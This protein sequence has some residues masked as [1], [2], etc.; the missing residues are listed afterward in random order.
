M[1]DPLATTAQT[2]VPPTVG[3]SLLDPN[4]SGDILRRYQIARNEEAA[5]T[6]RLQQAALADRVQ[7]DRET[8]DRDTKDYEEAQAFKQ[9]RG[10]VLESI[11]G[12][13]PDSDDYDTMVSD[14]LASAPEVAVKDDAVQALLSV[15]QRRR[16]EN[17]RLKQEDIRDKR[18]REENDNRW[19]NT[20]RES[21][22][23]Q[24]IDPGRY[25]RTPGVFDGTSAIK[26][27]AAAVKSK[28]TNEKLDKLLKERDEDDAKLFEKDQETLD[29]I[30]TGNLGA[31]RE[32]LKNRIEGSPVKLDAALMENVFTDTEDAFV[33]RAQKPIN[34]IPFTRGG[35]G[36]A[37]VELKDREPL[38]RSFADA[39]RAA[40][41][42][43]RGV[44]RLERRGGS[45]IGGAPSSPAPEKPKPVNAYLETLR[46][47]V[48]K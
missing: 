31:A 6:D 48:A 34:D 46:Q 26:D 40:Y 32:L 21:L 8:W 23:N 47:K 44:R 2:M 43:A 11:A 3:R 30:R 14:F 9:T 45:G 28:T 35:S 15:K 36:I 42:A 38:L 25:E 7:R 12:L 1:A 17:L 33:A 39:A 4:Q 27:L 13:D 22:I 37:G 24:G 29:Y 16:D 5:A 41:S 18:I 10:Q 19:S 20:I